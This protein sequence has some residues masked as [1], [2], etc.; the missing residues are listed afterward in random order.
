[1]AGSAIVVGVDGSDQALEAVRWAAAEAASRSLPLR[2]VS[3]VDPAIAVATA[4]PPVVLEAVDSIEQVAQADLEKAALL[5]RETADVTADTEYLPN[6]AVPVLVEQSKN[7]SLLVLGATGRGGY[8]GMVLGSTAVSVVA[9]SE[10]PV[11]VVRPAAEPAGPVVVGVDGSE[12]SLGALAAAFDEAARRRTPLVA[13]HS[14]F[15][16]DYL[17]VARHGALERELE[18]QEQTQVLVESLEGWQEKYPGV[19][20]QRVAVRDQPRHQLLDWSRKAQLVVVGSRGRGGFTGLVLGSTSQ[21]LIQHAS[22][23][24]MVVR[25]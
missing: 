4:G 22:C 13:V 5:A 6:S 25:G 1:M 11:V 20:V 9:H 7:A 8:V 18:A 19:A 12:T 21:A 2:A 14:W 16:S 24:V 15:D 23:P 10:C 3:A 17:L